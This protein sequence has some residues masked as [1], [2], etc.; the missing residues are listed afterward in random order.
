MT[1]VIAIRKSPPAIKLGDRA[2]IARREMKLTQPQFA[3]L[4]AEHLPAVNEKSYS[5]WETGTNPDDPVAVADALE[6]VTGYPWTW[7]LR[8]EVPFPTDGGSQ[9]RLGESNSRPSHYKA[10]PR[11][12]TLRPSTR[13][14]MRHPKGRAA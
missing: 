10:K 7:F 11:R 14:D 4:L 8:G 2:R 5:T 3:A 13:T 9:S 1:N 12:R 6:K